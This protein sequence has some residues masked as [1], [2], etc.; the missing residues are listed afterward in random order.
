MN[1]ALLPLAVGALAPSLPWSAARPALTTPPRRALLCFLP[2]AGAPVCT[3]D[4]KQLAAIASEWSGAG[5][6][7]V[8]ASVDGLAH[9]RRFLD[10]VGGAAL[11]A[12][13]DPELELARAFGVAWPQ[14]FAARASFL[15]EARSDGRFVVR[16]AAVHPI[17]FV[18]PLD[19]LRAWRAR[20]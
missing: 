6:P 11:H 17:A 14:R 19:A 12:I 9:L 4:A 16:A 15:L 20:D 7:I 5:C 18:R 10:E 8:V 13:G 3:P 2:L 1:G